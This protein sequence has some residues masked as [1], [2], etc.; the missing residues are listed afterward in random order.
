MK[1]EFELTDNQKAEIVE[2]LRADMIAEGVALAASERT[3]PY[4]VAEAAEELGVSASSIRREV[5]AGRIGRVPNTGRV[6]IPVRCVRA[7]QNGEV[8]CG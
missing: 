4:S 2:A 1:V 3:R 6:L 8:E 7:R 5:E